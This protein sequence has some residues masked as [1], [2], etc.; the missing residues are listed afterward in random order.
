MN[1]SNLKTF[2]ARKN[3]TSIGENAFSGCP[4][5]TVNFKN[6]KGW[7]YFDGTDTVLVSKDTDINNTANATEFF[8]K[9]CA[10]KWTRTE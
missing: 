1:C 9:N 10:Y 8:K 6:K 4:L 7:S 2:N 5:T 3:L